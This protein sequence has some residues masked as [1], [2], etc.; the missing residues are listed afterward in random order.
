MNMD[1]NFNK[2]VM[3]ALNDR[4]PQNGVRERLI[5]AAFAEGISATGN[6]SSLVG[7]TT[8]EMLASRYPQRSLFS[9]CPHAKQTHELRDLAPLTSALT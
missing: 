2:L 7:E 5:W 6:W 3:V 9:L 8:N 4:G 1:T